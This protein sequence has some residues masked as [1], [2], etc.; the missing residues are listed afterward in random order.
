MQNPRK[1]EMTRLRVLVKNLLRRGAFED[2]MRD[3]VQFHIDSRAADLIR[4]GL[5]PD[6]AARRARLEFGGSEGW[7]D[8]MREAGGLG[9]IDAVRIDL[10]YALRT[11]RRSPVFAC[12]AILS[13]ALGIGANTAVFH[14]VNVVRLRALPVP[15]PA[16][17]ASVRAKNS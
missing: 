17:L 16:Q 4:S 6:E 1:S 13:L 11:L 3:E 15:N 9:W 2:Q 8:L 12:V 14:L 5:R 10:R 7:K